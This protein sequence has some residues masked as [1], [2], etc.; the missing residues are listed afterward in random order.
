[1]KVCFYVEH[2]NNQP[3]RSTVESTPVPPYGFVPCID[4]AGVKRRCAYFHRTTRADQ[5]F[6]MCVWRRLAV[7]PL[8][9]SICGPCR[10]DGCS[11]G[12]VYKGGWRGSPRR[13][14]Y[15]DYEDAAPSAQRHGWYEKTEKRHC[16]KFVALTAPSQ[17]TH[18]R[19]FRS[20]EKLRC[21]A[22]D[23]N[24][25]LAHLGKR[26]RQCVIFLGYCVS[27]HPAIGLFSRNSSATGLRRQ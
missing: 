9:V 8:S 12:E 16:W 19:T 23:E 20:I 25:C 3:L 18:K 13:H 24:S 7:L 14:C 4:S 10:H 2:A 26:L 21:C 6:R 11:A 1:M 15:Q 22:E 17:R 27:Q 5:L